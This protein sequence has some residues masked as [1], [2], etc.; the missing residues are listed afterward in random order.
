MKILKTPQ[1]KKEAVKRNWHVIDAEG[2]V[3]GRLS[4]QIATLL[5]GKHKPDYT[6]HV[7][8]GDYVVVLNATKVVVTGRKQTD[9]IYARHSQYPGGFRQESFDKLQG[10]RPEAIIEKAVKGMLPKNRL[11]DPRLRRLK[12]FIGSEHTHASNIKAAK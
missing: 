1:L 11:Q 12:V 9:K 8:S 3:L 2:K 6:P 7:D 4:T 10:R 5:I